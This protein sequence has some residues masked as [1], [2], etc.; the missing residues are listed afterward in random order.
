MPA[1]RVGFV[2]LV[3]LLAAGSM[4]L[5]DSV[6]GLIASLVEKHADRVGSTMSLNLVTLLYL[7]ASVCFIQALKG[8]SHPTTSIRGNVFG[9]AG[10]TIAVVTTVR[11][12]RH[13][14]RRRRMGLGWVLLGP[15][16][17][18]H[19]RLDHGAGAWR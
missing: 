18:R 17:R 19:G 6:V 16:G 5:A 10:M 8:L 2:L 4:A 14:R 11:A 9:M 1:D 15:A 7:V 3:A 12:D 13:A